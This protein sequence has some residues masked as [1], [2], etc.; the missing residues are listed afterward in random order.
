MAQA[1]SLDSLG[2]D[3]IIERMRRQGL[4][5]A[6]MKAFFYILN[7]AVIDAIE[8]G[9]SVHLGL[10]KISCSISGAFIDSSDRYNSKR[11][12]IHVNLARGAAWRGIEKRITPEKTISR[13][14]YP[15]IHMIWDNTSGKAISTLTSGLIIKVFGSNLK[16]EGSDSACGL[17]FVDKAE[18]TK[19]T[20][21]ASERS[22]II[23]AVP[24]LAPG[25]Y[26]MQVKTQYSRGTMLKQPRD[27]QYY[28]VTVS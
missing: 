5:T 14:P 8:E 27:S 11:H 3:E 17:W 16:I 21:F 25:T 23:A 19:A 1:Y 2:E 6:D 12:K 18:R 10:M 13:E 24:K 9:Y 22:Q 4:R 26:S 28:I 15:D 7:K 20:V